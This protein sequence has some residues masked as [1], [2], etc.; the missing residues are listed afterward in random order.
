MLVAKREGKKIA[1]N[2]GILIEQ[3]I[4][5]ACHDGEIAANGETV[6]DAI[7]QPDA[8]TYFYINIS[9]GTVFHFP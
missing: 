9:W 3:L 4:N 8:A 7:F 5:P 6:T 1:A 2:G